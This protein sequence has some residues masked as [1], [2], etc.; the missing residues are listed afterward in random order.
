[1]QVPIHS[2]Y[3]VPWSFCNSLISLAMSLQHQ[4]NKV[5]FQCS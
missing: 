1:M 3:W 2:S 5:Y 4:P